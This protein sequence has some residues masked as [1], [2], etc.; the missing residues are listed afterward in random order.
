MPFALLIIGVVLL[1]SAVRGTQDN[2]AGLVKGD[3]T[4]QRN[5]IYWVTA[6]LAIGMLGY[7]KQLQPFSRAFLVLMAVAILLSNKGFFAQFQAQLSTTSQ[8]GVNNG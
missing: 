1:I 5:F 4:G 6:I 3:F 8:T 2:L 7:F